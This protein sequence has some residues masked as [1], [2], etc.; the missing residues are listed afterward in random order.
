M[1]EVPENIKK[2]FQYMHSL[3][4]S[5][6]KTLKE[7]GG[8]LK[9][10]G[11]GIDKD[12]VV[13]T[14]H[15]LNKIK[16]SE[17]SILRKVSVL[18]TKL[19]TKI[20]SLENISNEIKESLLNVDTKNKFDEVYKAIDIGKIEL[21]QRV[22]SEHIKPFQYEL[23][24]NYKSIN[25]L[26]QQIKIQ[27][28]NIESS[29][30]EVNCR[31]EVHREKI[32]KIENI[33]SEF[34]KE[35]DGIIN[36]QVSPIRAEILESEDKVKY[37]Y[38]KFKKRSKNVLNHFKEKTTNLENIFKET[39][40]DVE[41]VK[42]DVDKA[43]KGINSANSLHIQKLESSFAQSKLEMENLKC[44]IMISQRECYDDAK[45]DLMKSYQKDIAF[46][47][48][49]LRWL[50]SNLQD[51]SEM[52]P[53]EARL[54]TIETRIKTEE[55]T[56]IQE[57]NNLIQGILYIEL[58][59]I[60]PKEPNKKRH[61]EKIKP[62]CI[63]SRCFTPIPTTIKVCR[64]PGGMKILNSISNTRIK[65]SDFIDHPIT[66]NKNKAALALF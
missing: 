1:Q 39:I 13:M 43:I 5:Q 18:T 27:N 12:D 26:E 15:F 62:N 48:E 6:D 52:T 44:E 60:M 31:F 36:T 11:K 47:N 61:S 34:S 21:L 16:E 9:T 46:I 17:L 24:E 2:V 25:M 49:K 58:S 53:I 59:L 41:K 56:R 19:N 66:L 63:T 7:L 65:K 37:I 3:L 23:K 45:S 57:I 38:S 32:C 40:K 28:W 4:L 22:D 50:P 30:K 42:I 29:L 10:G 55:T 8:K 20:E 35:V 51:I 33:A 64:S 14:E 54:Y